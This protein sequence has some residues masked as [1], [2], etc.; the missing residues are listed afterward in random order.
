MEH[1]TQE[2]RAYATNT[3]IPNAADDPIMG[4]VPP[5]TEEIILAKREVDANEK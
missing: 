5:T 4:L 3:L 1:K 2:E